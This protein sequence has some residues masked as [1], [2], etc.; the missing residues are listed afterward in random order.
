MV[1]PRMASDVEV[2]TVGIAAVESM[3]IA[4]YPNP[5][6]GVVSISGIGQLRVYNISGQLLKTI[7]LS[8]DE[9]LLHDLPQGVYT[10]VLTNEKIKSI[11]KLIVY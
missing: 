4:M 1:Y 8:G 2:H 6:E 5:S 11:E 7:H 3:Q 9:V 10:C